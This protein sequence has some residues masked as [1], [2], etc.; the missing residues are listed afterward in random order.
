VRT[1]VALVV[2]QRVAVERQ[3]QL[4]HGA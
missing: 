4:G 3:D 1:G 2:L